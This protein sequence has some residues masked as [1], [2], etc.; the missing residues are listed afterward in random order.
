M[1]TSDPKDNYLI[2]VAKACDF[3][4][5]PFRHAVIDNSVSPNLTTDQDNFDL[6]LLV[7]CRDQNGTRLTEN[8]LDVEIYKSGVDLSI[9]LS[10]HSFPNKP[11]LWQ[12]KHSLWMDSLSGKRAQ[13]PEQ[14]HLLEALARR[15][16]SYFVVEE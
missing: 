14:G 3:C 12:G 8:D 5:K 16:R 10:W 13:I 15:L 2:E 9:T 4:I 11:I 1:C 6:T 7:V